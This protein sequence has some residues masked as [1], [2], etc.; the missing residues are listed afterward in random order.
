VEEFGLVPDPED[1]KYLEEDLFA[2]ADPRIFVS[3]PHDL[4]EARTF[5]WSPAGWFERIE[6]DSGAVEFSPVA[7]DEEELREWLSEQGIEI[8]EIDIDNAFAADVRE[9]F[10][11]QTPLYP[12]APEVSD[13]E[14]P[15]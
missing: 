12:E 8:T 6:G 15:T 4:D 9:E 13:Q 5:V 1:P 14:L 2:G 10:L 11:E 7:L 3:D